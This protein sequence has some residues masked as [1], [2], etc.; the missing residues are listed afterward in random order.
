MTKQAIKAKLLENF[1]ALDYIFFGKPVR[2]VKDFCCPALVESYLTT[3]GALLSVMLEVYKVTGYSPK[4]SKKIT[5]KLI[6]EN[7]KSLSKEV[8]KDVKDLLISESGAKSIRNKVSQYLTESNKITSEIIKEAIKE[9]AFSVAIDRLLLGSIVQECDHFEELDSKDG[10]VIEEAYRL[11][12]TDLAE[13][14][15][16]M[17]DSIEIERQ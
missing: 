15:V 1:Y 13:T 14:A 6:H 16:I 3:K 10:K 17:H 8:K 7:A 5:A 12:R 11:L 9:K 4:I 2:K